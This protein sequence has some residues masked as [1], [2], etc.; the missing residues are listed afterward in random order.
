ML[1]AGT[2][3]IWLAETQLRDRAEVKDTALQADLTPNPIA[4]PDAAGENSSQTTNAKNPEESRES[5][6]SAPVSPRSSA[7]PADKKGEFESGNLQAWELAAAKLAS[8]EV[9][10]PD[11]GMQRRFLLATN[12]VYSRADGAGG[13]V[14][15]ISGDGS[16]SRYFENIRAASI[17]LAT[18]Q[19]I[20]YESG[21]PRSESS[22]RV[23]T[24]QVLI[25]APTQEIAEEIGAR[26]GLAFKEA[27]VYAPGKFIFEAASAWDV[28]PLLAGRSETITQ[29]NVQPLLGAK[30]FT[31]SAPND[32]LFNNQW[33]LE[34]L[35]LTGAVAAASANVSTLWGYSGGPATRGTGVVVGIVDDGL[36]AYHPDL[37]SNMNLTLGWDWVDQDNNP[38]PALND[39][40]GT[41]VAGNV[42]AT[43]NNTLGVIGAAPEAILVGMRL[44]GGATTD[45]DIAGTIAHHIQEIDIKNNSWGDGGGAG[46]G[47]TLNGVGSLTAAALQHA[48]TNGRQG[49]GSIMVWAGGN[50]RQSMDSS[51]YSG[52]P[53]TIHG[54]AVA[55]MDSRSRQSV[56]SES[57][58]NLAVCA[59]S[60][61][62]SMV[63]GI[64]TTDL[65]G[66]KG[67]NRGDSIRDFQNFPD[68][69]RRFGGTSSAAPT[70]SGIIA[71]LLQANPSLSPRDVKEILMKTAAKVQPQDIDWITNNGSFN[72]N[73]KFG[74]GR[75]DAAAAVALAQNW[76][77]LPP[78]ITANATENTVVQ[79]ADNA[80]AGITKSLTI[81]TT[82]AIRA[83]HVTLG[84][85]IP[86]VAKGQLSIV[87]TS[88]S[89]TQSVFCEPHWDTS[90]Q[91]L[92]WTF[93]TVR[94]W[95]ESANG[96]WTVNVADLK[97][98]QTGNW[99]ET[100]LTVYGSSLSANDPPPTVRIVSPG[101][102][103][104]VRFPATVSVNATD[105][106]IN[107]NA[108][109]LS[110]VDLLVNDVVVGSDSTSPYS[111]TWNRTTIRQAEYALKAR[112]YD[113]TGTV[114]TTSLPV[115]VYAHNKN[116]V[117]GWDFESHSTNQSE[118]SLE[119][120][121]Q[122]IGIYLRNWGSNNATDSQMIFDG[123][124]GSSSWDVAAGEIWSGTGST[125]NSNPDFAKA[126]STSSGLALRA[127][128]NLSAN[129]K[130]II[131]KLNLTG[132]TNL[133]I[134]YAT[135]FRDG[136]FTTHT[137]DFWNPDAGAWRTIRTFDGLTN[138]SVLNRT[139]YFVQRMANL[140]VS[141]FNGKPE[142]FVRLTVSG[143]TAVHG[144]NFFDNIRFN[145]TVAP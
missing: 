118:E 141:G 27:P 108:T 49:R 40:H 14:L 138:V 25:E 21:L 37:R 22:R 2:L 92:D 18:S 50:G 30:L 142:A 105:F 70:V 110:K 15:A 133:E 116:L 10:L 90:N 102:Q 132:A 23:V 55:A 84:V 59:P 125:S 4:A 145:A 134:S 107:G 42:A 66:E 58:A 31:Q 144:I 13:S 68:Y 104:S 76:K 78:L 139:E 65:P 86:G 64:A 5:L 124:L 16:A 26:N 97:T 44:L 87:L 41:A 88:P 29:G 103:T 1:S 109:S 62:D 96:N 129:G 74:A 8:Q 56:Y 52:F 83:E 111:F 143:A 38:E 54:I 80:A 71:L 57:G 100:T 12:E 117:A 48:A 140:N 99:T 45:A 33:H 24:K 61:G 72:F 136:G 75:V 47:R 51:N 3:L 73:H 130:S 67:Q 79:I 39:S 20:L 101:N 7:H 112:A 127:G 81:S 114:F 135:V 137:W 91:F 89:G 60:S 93:M 123:T 128:K 11:T 6:T 94:C 9:P 32:A 120:A 35:P 122:S 119:S 17:P 95:G 63:L 98:G 46:S 43:G 126:I 53:N 106:D 131:F 115:T 113:S 77:N 82:P 121:A 69:T 34:F 19:P 36:D 28:L 85:K